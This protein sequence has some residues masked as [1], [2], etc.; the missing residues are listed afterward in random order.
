MGKRGRPPKK[1]VE[2]M[3]RATSAA[4][5]FGAKNAA[6]VVQKNARTL[7]KLQQ[8][9]EFKEVAKGTELE[10]HPNVLVINERIDMLK[11]RIDRRLIKLSR[12][13]DGPHRGKEHSTIATGFLHAIPN[14][15]VAAADAA[16]KKAT[17]AAQEAKRQGM[18]DSDD[19]D[20][21]SSAN[22]KGVKFQR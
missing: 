22:A 10:V 19:D 4:A 9:M 15:M 21:S 17:A 7:I 1:K 18:D 3:A 8:L 6:R 2:E 16:A 11:K 14:A 13:A 12:W 5:P 20:R